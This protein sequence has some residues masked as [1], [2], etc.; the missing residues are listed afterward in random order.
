MKG[1]FHFYE[2]YSMQDVV[3]PV[4]VM[5]QIWHQAADRV[6]CKRGIKPGILQSV[7]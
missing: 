3:F 2:G 7:I 4:R 6:K 5:K 1:R